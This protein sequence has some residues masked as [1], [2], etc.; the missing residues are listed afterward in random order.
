[1]YCR[2]PWDNSSTFHNVSTDIILVISPITGQSNWYH[3]IIII[4]S[5][6]IQYY[7]ILF[8][9]CF[10]ETTA[11]LLYKNNRRLCRPKHNYLI[12]LNYINT[13]I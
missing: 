2:G 4:V 1:M 9:I 6:K 13:F 10:T 7:H 5:N 11:K 12:D 3:K 8:T